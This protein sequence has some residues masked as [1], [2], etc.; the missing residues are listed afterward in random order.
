[1][2]YRHGELELVSVAKVEGKKVNHNVLAEGEATG[3]KHEV[4]GDAQLYEDNG[5]LY[6]HADS[7]VELIHPDHDTVKLP[8]GDYRVDVQKEYVVGDDK[9]AKVTD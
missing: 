1:M 8:K 2:F 6:L 4:I 9:Y 3:H 7:E 5:V